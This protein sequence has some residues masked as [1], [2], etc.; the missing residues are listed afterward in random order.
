MVVGAAGLHVLSGHPQGGSAPLVWGCLWW[1]RGQAVDSVWSQSSG[2]GLT[3]VWEGYVT[4]SV[5]C[6]KGR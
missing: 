6:L 4:G 2:L 3:L 1:G 5:S